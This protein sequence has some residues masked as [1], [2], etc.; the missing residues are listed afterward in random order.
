VLVDVLDVVPV[1]LGDMDE[2]HLAALQGQEGAVRGDAA[3]GPV[4][5]RAD[6]EICQDSSFY[7][8]TVIRRVV[9][10]RRIAGEASVP[11]A[12]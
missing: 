10:L 1:G 9:P 12:F 5:D 7:R 6:L 11:S 8:T 3:H 2:S 4:D